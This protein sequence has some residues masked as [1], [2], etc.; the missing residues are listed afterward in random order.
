M[1]INIY[2]D[3][4]NFSK[5][6]VNLIQ[7][8]RCPI[9]TTSEIVMTSPSTPQ[10]TF[11]FSA[12]YILRLVENN[13]HLF[14]LVSLQKLIII[15]I[16]ILRSDGLLS[17]SIPQQLST[18]S[19]ARLASVWQQVVCIISTFQTK[20]LGRDLTVEKTKTDSGQQFGS[21]M[22]YLSSTQANESFKQNC[23]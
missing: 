8:Y 17:K 7:R 6:Y 15:T 3:Y 12:R 1:S 2:Q 16:N 10:E 11:Y 13:K 4:S 21:E 19:L 22:K 14:T 23:F 20:E 9:N 5:S 18:D